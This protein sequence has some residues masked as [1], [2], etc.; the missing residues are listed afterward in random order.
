MASGGGASWPGLSS[1]STALAALEREVIAAAAAAASDGGTGAAPP[2]APAMASLNRSEFTSMMPASI[3]IMT[4]NSFATTNIEGAVTS[5][6][7]LKVNVVTTCGGAGANRDMAWLTANVLSIVPGVLSVHGVA[8]HGAG[9]LRVHGVGAGISIVAD[10]AGGTA[11]THA[12]V[13]VEGMGDTPPMGID[14]ALAMVGNPPKRL[15]AG[16]SGPAPLVLGGGVPTLAAAQ[17]A[18]TTIPAA[19]VVGG[20]ALAP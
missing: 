20:S 17:Q 3:L 1:F 10:P 2:A 7:A 4:D 9:G 8:G 5:S 13:S 16:G 11:V 15:W 19:E 12:C 18:T 6:G 14:A